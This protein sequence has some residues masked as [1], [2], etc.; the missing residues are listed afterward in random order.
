MSETRLSYE[1]V[2]AFRDKYPK[3][4]L[5]FWHVKNENAHKNAIALGIVAGVA[6]MHYSK[7]DGKMLYM[8]LKCPGKVHVSKKVMQQ[9]RWGIEQ[10]RLGHTWRLVTSVDQA[11]DLIE[12]REAGLRPKQVLDLLINKTIAF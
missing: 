10:E 12:G 4:R 3:Q 9:V 7:E 5:R 8:E 6:D 11:M 1:L 2:K